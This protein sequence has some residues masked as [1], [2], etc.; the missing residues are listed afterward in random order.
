LSAWNFCSRKLLLIFI[1]IF[2][3]IKQKFKRWISEV[4]FYQ[5]QILKVIL[6]VIFWPS[7][8]SIG[9]DHKFL[10]CNCRTIF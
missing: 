6:E 3:M 2:G 7:E 9:R 4:I 10:E 1:W 5:Q 8:L